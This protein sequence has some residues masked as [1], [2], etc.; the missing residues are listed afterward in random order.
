MTLTFTVP[1]DGIYDFAT[2]QTQAADY[3]DIIYAIDGTPVGGVFAGTTPR[4]PLTTG[5]STAP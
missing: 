2:T 3:G 1:E 4:L 5:S